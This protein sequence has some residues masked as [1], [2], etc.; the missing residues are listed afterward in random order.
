MITNVDASV[1]RSGPRY[2]PVTD[3]EAARRDR[4]G[5]APRTSVDAAVADSCHVVNA[6][7]V[8]GLCLHV[9][10]QRS[11]ICCELSL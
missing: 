4:P 10:S 8:G 7:A 6:Q 11:K 9:A 2:Q 5:V 3:V 1:N